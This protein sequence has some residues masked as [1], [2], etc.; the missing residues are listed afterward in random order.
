MK[1]EISDNANITANSK[2][3]EVL[4]EH[5]PNCFDKD[6][7]FLPAKLETLVKE[8]GADISRE[9]YSLNWLGKSYARLLAN[10][11]V[12]TLLA[13]NT[14]HNAKPENA[15]SENLLI[16]GDNLEVLKH[17]KNAY[18]EKVKM[19]YIDP[20]YNTGSDG[21]VYADDRKFTPDQLSQLAGI[22]ED[23]AKRILEF[24][25]SKSNSHS[26]W[27]TFMF[28][29]LY[30][31]RELLREDGA[32]FISIDENEQAQ[33][34]MLCDEI[35][36]EE[37]FIECITWNKRI[38]KND[39]GIGNIHE[40]VLLYSK[41][42]DSKLKF[43]MPKEGLSEI[44]DFLSKLKRS[45]ISQLE[46][47]KKLKRFYKKAD[48][49]RGITLYNCI[50]ENY[51]L[52][53]KINMSWPNP[54]TEGPRYT[55]FHPRSKRSVKIPERG[56][57]WKQT[58]FNEE[59]SIRDGEYTSIV[60]R[61]DGSIICGNIWF[62]KDEKTQP[63]SITYLKDVESFLLRSILS[64]KSDGG[65][66]LKALFNKK[67]LFSRPKGTNLLKTLIS[68]LGANTDTYIL[69]FF[70]GSGTTAH[71]IMALNAE[72][73]GNRK[74]ISVQLDEPTDPKS[75]AYKA[76]YKTIFEITRERIKRAA[77]KIKE[78][79]PEAKCD[80]G[81]KEFKTIEPFEGYLDEAETLDQYEAFQADKLGDK[82]R[83]QLMLTWQAYDGLPLHLELSPINLTGYTAHQGDELLYFMNAGLELKHMVNLLE[84]IDSDKTFAPRKLV[85]FGQLLSSK[86]QREISEAIS[87]YNNRKGIELTL[88]IRF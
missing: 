76:G 19:I 38:P 24:T 49:D 62:S 69:D 86:A 22:D 2:Q 88:D 71:A 75:E 57:R 29:R 1:K 77:V 41:R 46:A 81:F 10:E 14:D 44:F 7:A 28:P 21:F 55:V 18:R 60:E 33:L 39:K 70:S 50:N 66:E 13:A 40:Y 72:D 26:A 30:I 45:N 27:L 63:S 80:F 51:E 79:N 53:G 11:N 68:S 15:N 32:I 34:K 43:L 31:A 37:N 54:S 61:D 64:L 73:G 42:E 85:V 65:V 20:P 9:G 47:E 82:E 78:E 23:E 25:Q 87:S 56:W 4:K 58:T 67:V 59:A 83:G 8:T 6:G 48:Y 74:C 5:F 84:R 12:R 17:L 3:L 52:W 35:F 16:Q 36:G